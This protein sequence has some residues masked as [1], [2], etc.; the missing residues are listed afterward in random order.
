MK[1]SNIKLI[2]LSFFSLLLIS[3]WIFKFADAQSVATS[4]AEAAPTSTPLLLR[5]MAASS[6][7]STTTQPT[8]T[9][10]PVKKISSLKFSINFQDQ[11]FVV[12][13]ETLDLWKGAQA[14]S[15]N[16]LLQDNPPKVSDSLLKS[17]GQ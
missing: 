14:F 1:S 6:S 15:K 7:P 11:N 12:D 9:P 8:P 13:P 17:L 3:G 10:S 16:N 2:S 4:T 5:G